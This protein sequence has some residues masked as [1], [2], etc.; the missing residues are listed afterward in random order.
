MAHAETAVGSLG[1]SA[2]LDALLHSEVSIDPYFEIVLAK[3]I[4]G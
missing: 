2:L 4:G 1:A 3:S